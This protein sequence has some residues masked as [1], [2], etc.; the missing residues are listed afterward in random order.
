MSIKNTLDT[1]LFLKR[2]TLLA[3]LSLDLLLAIAEKAHSLEIKE[4]DV[5]FQPDQEAHKMYFI[6]EGGVRVEDRDHQLLGLLYAGEC[7]GEESLFSDTNRGYWAIAETDTTLLV[8]LKSHLMTLIA[9]TPTIAL[10]FLHLYTS[11]HPFRTRT[12]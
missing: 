4:G 8:L 7:F 9:E 2:Q 6:L 12:L 3:D 1:A 11:Q 10:H 5:L